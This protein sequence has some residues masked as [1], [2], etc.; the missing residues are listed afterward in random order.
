ME[1]MY[2]EGAKSLRACAAIQLNFMVYVR[3]SSQLLSSYCVVCVLAGVT[4]GRGEDGCGH[5]HVGG[6]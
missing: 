1:D 4:R 6:A 5:P 2:V 3:G